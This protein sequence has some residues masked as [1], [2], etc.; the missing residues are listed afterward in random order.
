MPSGASAPPPPTQTTTATTKPKADLRLL[1][2][3]TS[4]YPRLK[5]PANAKGASSAKLQPPQ[6]LKDLES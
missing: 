1:M 6:T 2:K 5:K 4:F 3:K